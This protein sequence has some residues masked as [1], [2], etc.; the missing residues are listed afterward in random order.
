MACNENK[1]QQK[2]AKRNKRSAEIKKQ[3]NKS[4]NTSNRDFLLAAAKAPWVGCYMSEASGMYNIVAIRQSRSGP[5]ACLFLA[6]VYC[7]GVKDAYLIRSFDLGAFQEDARERDFETIPPAKA[8]KLISKS[9]EY[10]R[11][12]GFEPHRDALTCSLIFSD[13]DANECTE[14][15]EFGSDGKPLYTS[16]PRDS[17]ERQVMIMN[18]LAK[19]GEGNYHFM[20]GGLLSPDFS[21]LHRQ[22]DEDFDGEDLDDDDEDDEDDDSFPSIGERVVRFVK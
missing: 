6:D 21:I 19:L 14:E 2:L 9:I 4:V 22:G 10:A 8:L 11:G 12:I 17:R 3:R 13:V 7:L 1:R 20:L 16:G 5:I 15:F 18:T